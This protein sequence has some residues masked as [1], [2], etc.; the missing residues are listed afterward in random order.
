MYLSGGNATANV[1]LSP[2]GNDVI[3]LAR[4]RS[5]GYEGRNLAEWAEIQVTLHHYERNLSAQKHLRLFNQDG[6]SRRDN[7]CKRFKGAIEG[8]RYNSNH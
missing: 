4:L 6:E 8:Q 5:I 2:A 7:K 3:W 1:S